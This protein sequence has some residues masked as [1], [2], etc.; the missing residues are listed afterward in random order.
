[1]FEKIGFG[2][3]LP[4]HVGEEKGKARGRQDEDGEKGRCKYIHMF[5][6]QNKSPCKRIFFLLYFKFLVGFH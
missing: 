3:N 5:I 4:D 2:V 1:M 6:K